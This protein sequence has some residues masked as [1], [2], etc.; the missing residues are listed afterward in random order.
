MSKVNFKGHT[1]CIFF[2]VQSTVKTSFSR[3]PSKP[4]VRNPLTS[5]KSHGQGQ[6]ISPPLSGVGCPIPSIGA[7]NKS[8]DSPTAL[9][10]EF[11]LSGGSIDIA[12][13]GS[14]SW[15]EGGGAGEE[16][17]FMIPEDT[18]ILD[19]SL[20]SSL[21]SLCGM[22]DLEASPDVSEL[23]TPKNVAIIQATLKSLNFPLNCGSPT[24]QDTFQ[25]LHESTVLQS[26]A[27]LIQTCIM[28]RTL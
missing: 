15:G 7:T 10:K 8:L 21:S 27:L 28:I 9:E 17:Y 11:L 20:T 6:G 24:N 2:T 3:P 25:P 23:M 16:E 26:G 13:K 22:K 18:A 19:S 4:R 5:L 1:I 12:G 14:A